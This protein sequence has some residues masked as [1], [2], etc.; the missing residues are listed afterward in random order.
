MTA[1]QWKL[2]IA[3]LGLWGQG[4]VRQPT[5]QVDGHLAGLVVA[6]WRR[7]V[8]P[9]S[10]S[11]SGALIFS[12]SGAPL[13]DMPDPRDIRHLGLPIAADGPK[14]DA[15]TAAVQPPPSTEGTGAWGRH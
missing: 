13:G 1:G 5:G 8:T 9:L 7:G 4:G 12:C 10:E 6:W 11:W 3:R 14:V 2:L 15:G